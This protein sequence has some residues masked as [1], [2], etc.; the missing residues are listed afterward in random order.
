[1]QIAWLK[2][3]VDRAEVVADLRQGLHEGAAVERDADDAGRAEGDLLLGHADE[4][5]VAPC[6][7]AASSMP[8][9][10]VAAFAL[11]EFTNT[12]RRRARSH[13]S[14]VMITGAAGAAVG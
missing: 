9:R 2:R 12:A 6:V 5:D 8:V 7:R 13:R 1:M 4:I 10:P 3:V 11:P 14:R